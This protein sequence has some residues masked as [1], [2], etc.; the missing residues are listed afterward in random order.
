MGAANRQ[1]RAG[2]RRSQAPKT[3]RGSSISWSRVSI[4]IRR[5]VRRGHQPLDTRLFLDRNHDRARAYIDRAAAHKPN[6][7]A[8]LKR[9]STKDSKRST[10]AKWCAPRVV[11]RT[12]SIRRPHDARSASSPNRSSRCRHTC[13]SPAAPA[14]RK[15]V[16]R[17]S[18]LADATLA[19]A[20]LRLVDSRG[21]DR[22]G[23][24]YCLRVRRAE[25]PRRLVPRSG[26]QRTP[27]TLVTPQSP[28]P[29]PSPMKPMWGRRAPCLRVES[30]AMRSA[31][32]RV[33]VGDALR[34]D[35]ERLRADIQREL[36]PWPARASSAS[37][38][39]A[40][41]SPPRE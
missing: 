39:V 3:T 27:A 34:P 13:T 29:I 21:R 18:P 9:W 15:R 2:Q 31:P 12:P 23:R 5:R 24:W 4:T 14:A 33:P 30:C 25:W 35:A 37:S 32:D 40:P 1:A 16:L 8:S 7:I 26:H 19:A 11:E 38:I 6:S 20:R 41:G 36:L 22:A 28:L 17:R 10:R